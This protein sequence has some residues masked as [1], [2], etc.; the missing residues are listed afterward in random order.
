M[1]SIGVGAE[2]LR[3]KDRHGIYRVFYLAR[4]A[5]VVLVFHAFQ[6]KIQKTPQHEIEL[7]KKKLKEMLHEEE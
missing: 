6:K 1:P 2:E 5:D 3:V 4:K 7:G